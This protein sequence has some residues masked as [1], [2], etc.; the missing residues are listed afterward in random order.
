MFGL[1]QKSQTHPPSAMMARA[2]ASDGLPPGMDPSTLAVVQRNG[3]YVGRRVTYFRVFD[4]Q[5]VAERGL[6]V[7]RFDDL[8]ASPDLV[9]ATGHLENTGA[10]V[11]AKRNRPEVTSTAVMR[12]QA[13]RSAHGED[14]AIVFPGGTD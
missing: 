11:L 8:D 3:S 7:R 14:E 10:V 4:P 6:E 1:F 12:D 9:L 13:D 2:L 5:R